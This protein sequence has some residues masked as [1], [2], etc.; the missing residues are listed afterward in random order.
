LLTT[1][2][3]QKSVKSIFDIGQNKDALNTFVG[4]PVIFGADFE[5]LK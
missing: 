2:A 3:K 4:D 5:E 1:R